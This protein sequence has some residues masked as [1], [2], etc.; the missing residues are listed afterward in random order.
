MA[1]Y[2]IGCTSIDALDVFSC[3]SC[4]CNSTFTLIHKEA[5]MLASV[6]CPHSQHV[7]SALGHSIHQSKQ[8]LVCESMFS[9][10]FDDLLC[11]MQAAIELAG[12]RQSI[13]EQSAEYARLTALHKA[14]AD[15]AD[16]A[17]QEVILHPFA[18]GL[19]SKLIYGYI[20]WGCHANRSRMYI[21]LRG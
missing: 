10:R 2:A 18:S 5:P 12:S 11:N 17:A 19:D 1:D 3:A 7:Q 16:R 4:T 21:C 8:K 14:E 15:R 20:T 13:A 9:K 6:A